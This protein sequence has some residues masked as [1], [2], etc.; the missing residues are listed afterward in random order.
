VKVIQAKNASEIFKQ[1]AAGKMSMKDGLGMM[2]LL[3]E[4]VTIEELPKLMAQ[5]AE[6]ES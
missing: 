1:V 5:L 3:K 4:Q 6:M 2:A